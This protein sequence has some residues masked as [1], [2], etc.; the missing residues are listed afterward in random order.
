MPKYTNDFKNSLSLAAKVLANFWIE[1]Y[2]DGNSGT[3]KNFT[4]AKTDTIGWSSQQLCLFLDSLLELSIKSP[5]PVAALEKMADLYGFSKSKNAE[6]C[7]RWQQL[8][9]KAGASWII[10]QVVEFITSN[11]RM[12]FV[13]PLYRALRTSNVGGRIANEVFQKHKM[14]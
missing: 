13:R 10:P 12:K 1:I 7:L 11:G 9:L 2:K 6:I 4:P 14:M 3:S 5:L 8:G